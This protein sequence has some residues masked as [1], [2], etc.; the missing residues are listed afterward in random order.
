M[1]V[2]GPV[3]VIIETNAYINNSVYEVTRTINKR[4]LLMKMEPYK[5]RM[6]RLADRSA[7]ILSHR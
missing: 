4:K 5:R 1:S 3:A 2:D 7:L 6:A